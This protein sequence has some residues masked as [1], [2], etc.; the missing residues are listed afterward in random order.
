MGILCGAMDI[1]QELT[2]I[3]V[4]E[5]GQGLGK[6]VVGWGCTEGLRLCYDC[7]LGKSRRRAPRLSA[8]S[9]SGENIRRDSMDHRIA[10]IRPYLRYAA[11][12]V[13]EVGVTDDGMPV[14][15][16]GI[17]I[18]K[19]ASHKLGSGCDPLRVQMALDWVWGV[20]C[21]RTHMISTSLH[22]T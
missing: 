4:A 15:D 8:Y 21:G 17:V 14:W 13:A 7:R 19:P 20:G 18:P 22:D 16:L 6:E 3:G 11:A 9:R 1:A 2:S 5:R 12:S 10:R